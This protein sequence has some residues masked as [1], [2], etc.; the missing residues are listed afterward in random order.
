[1]THPEDQ[2][3]NLNRRPALLDNVSYTGWIIG[4]LA[5]L[6]VVGVMFYTFSG[7]SSTQVATETMPERPAVTAPATTGAA[8]PTTTG[9]GTTAPAPSNP[10]PV[11]R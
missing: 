3:P 2:N 1:M 9:S 7:D 10:P 5:I 4:G 6:A 11:N 8:P